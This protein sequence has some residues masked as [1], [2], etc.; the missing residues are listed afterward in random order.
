MQEFTVL[1]T[2]SLPRETQRLERDV[3]PQFVSELEAIDDSACGP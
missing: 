1:H 3:E 2:R